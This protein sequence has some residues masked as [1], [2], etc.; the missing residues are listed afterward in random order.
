[1]FPEHQ[2]WG[3]AGIEYRNVARNSRVNSAQVVRRSPRDFCQTAAPSGISPTV[4]GLQATY[5]LY[6]RSFP[7]ET[8]HGHRES[9]SASLS[10]M[11][12]YAW[13]LL[14]FGFAQTRFFSQSCLSR[15]P[16][17][18]GNWDFKAVFRQSHDAISFALPHSDTQLFSFQRTS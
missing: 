10:V 17:V 3:P 9:W 2:R 5:Y 7:G 8:F 14:V 13:L 1:M 6:F 15:S 12:R 11:T 16:F 4:H 18:R